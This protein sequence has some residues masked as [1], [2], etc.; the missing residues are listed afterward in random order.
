M[1]INRVVAVSAGLIFMGIG[2]VMLQGLLVIVGFQ[3]IVLA[4]VFENKEK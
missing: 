4:I 2:M 1:R 3:T